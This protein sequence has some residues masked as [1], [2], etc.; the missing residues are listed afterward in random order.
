MQHNVTVGEPVPSA[1]LAPRVVD[2]PQRTMPLAECKAH[3]ANDAS[4]WIASR[5]AMCESRWFA[6]EWIVNGK[7]VGFT[8]MT[9]SA[10]ATVP[11][12]DSRE[13][14]FDYY[15]SDFYAAGTNAID[16]TLVGTDPNYVTVPD[17]IALTQGGLDPGPRSVAQI[18]A[19]P[20]FMVSRRAEPGQGA[21][22]NMKFEPQWP[23]PWVET[24]PLAE[25]KFSSFGLRWDN[26]SYLP[27]Y[28]PADVLH[29]GGASL[30]YNV[31]P[32]R[33]STAATAE[34]QAVARRASS[35]PRC[36]PAARGT[37]TLGS[38]AAAAL[39]LPAGPAS[40]LPHGPV[41]LLLASRGPRVGAA[42]IGSANASGPYGCLCCATHPGG[43]H[44]RGIRHPPG[45]EPGPTEPC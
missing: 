45:L 41:S 43:L 13:I 35:C 39:G 12:A 44:S 8:Q 38:G 5:F 27:N 30:S 40:S 3:T 34:E 2:D 9:V 19:D 22:W 26:S 33:Y 14:Y 15:F 7:V 11:A 31:S 32:L 42:G 37:V 10:I 1:G 17:N 16:A 4:M 36:R 24:N 21:I 28:K 23:A 25:W 18:K 20:H 6:A 29:T